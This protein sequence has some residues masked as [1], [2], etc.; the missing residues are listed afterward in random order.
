MNLQST[1][2][3]KQ[4]EVKQFIMKEPEQI[5]HSN[6]GINNNN[7]NISITTGS[8]KEKQDISKHKGSMKLA[9][10]QVDSNQE[11]SIDLSMQ[12]DY[13]QH[14]PLVSNSGLYSPSLLLL[15]LPNSIYDIHQAKFQNQ[16]INYMNIDSL[17]QQRNS[18]R[19]KSPKSKIKNSDKHANKRLS[20]PPLP[21]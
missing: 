10:K 19:N 14:S 9:K 12:R 13:Y 2:N 21:T 16:T 1:R 8:V 7:F 3:Q 11:L 15:A 20:M 17:S 18:I 6:L 4:V 5:F